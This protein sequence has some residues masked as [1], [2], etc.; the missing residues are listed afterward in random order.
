MAGLSID[1][2]GEQQGI[3]KTTYYYRMRRV[4]DHLYRSTGVLPELPSRSLNEQY[5]AQKDLQ[6]NISNEPSVYSTKNR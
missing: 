4:R 6:I 3:S 5:Y 2:F 1:T